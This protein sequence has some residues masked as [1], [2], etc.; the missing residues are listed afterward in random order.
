[1]TEAEKKVKALCIYGGER[2]HDL[3]D[4]LP[5]SEIKGDAFV[6]T[7]AKLCVLLAKEKHRPLGGK[8]LN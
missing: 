5:E 6:K 2:V 3:V 4:S 8:V 7:M 1:M